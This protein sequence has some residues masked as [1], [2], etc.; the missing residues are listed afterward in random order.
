MM[1]LHSIQRHL[2]RF[3]FGTKGTLCACFDQL[4]SCRKL[5]LCRILRVA[6]E[7]IRV[8]KKR[9]CL[10]LLDLI[11]LR[12]RV[13]INWL[14]CRLIGVSWQYHIAIPTGSYI[15]PLR[16]TNS[17]IAASKIEKQRLAQVRKSAK[18][19]GHTESLICDLICDWLSIGAAKYTSS[20]IYPVPFDRLEIN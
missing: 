9:K 12:C 1:I 4:N 5:A 15:Y 16:N 13:R 17:W 3:G 7:F 6:R 20:C 11:N 19:T 14:R 10:A 18:S 2:L 8:G